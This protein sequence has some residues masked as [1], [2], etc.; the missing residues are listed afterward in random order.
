MTALRSHARARP[1]PACVTLAILA[2]AAGPHATRNPA[3]GSGACP[4]VD[5]FTVTAEHRYR[6]AVRVR[7]LLFWIRRDNVGD[8]RL[9]WS[10]APDGA[11]RLELLIGSDPARAPMRVNRWGYIAE[12]ACGAATTVVGVMTE[13]DEQ[14][15]EDAR[16][17]VSDGGHAF[18]AIRAVITPAESVAS[19]TRLQVAEPFTYRDLDRLLRRLPNQGGVNRRLTLGEDVHQGFLMAT[20]ALVHDTAASYR[21][22]GRTGADPAASRAYVHGDRV[23]DLRVRGSGVVQPERRTVAS[24]PLLETEFE[25]RHRA[26][27]D[28]STF[29]LTYAPGGPLAEVPVRIVYRPRWW[30]E[31]ELQLADEHGAAVPRT[32][33]D[34]R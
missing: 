30:F 24:A 5:A 6:L 33:T 18:R 13:S 9:T 7:P 23:F 34:T 3:A 20:A 12:T 25:V 17:R 14:S 19:V 21:R 31:A 22:A 29:R 2:L 16:A 26:S 32:R 15:V 4:A 28:T 11:A 27:G 10:A 8:A 1:T